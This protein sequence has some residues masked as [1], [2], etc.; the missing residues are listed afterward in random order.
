MEGIREEFK[1]VMEFLKEEFPNGEQTFFSRN[2]S[3]DEMRNIYSEDGIRIDY[4]S[5]WGYIEIFGLTKD[6]Q[7]RLEYYTNYCSMPS[8]DW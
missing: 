5:Y 1:K 3:G 6:E 2:I 8:R 7:E 4:C